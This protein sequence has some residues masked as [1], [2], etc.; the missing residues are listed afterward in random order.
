MKYSIGGLIND[1][2]KWAWMEQHWGDRIFNFLFGYCEMNFNNWTRA[3]THWPKIQRILKAKTGLEFELFND[4]IYVY[5]DEQYM[6]EHLLEMNIS[7]Y[8][9]PEPPPSR[10]RNMLNNLKNNDEE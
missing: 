9:R 6:D 8:Q 5:I 1:Q 3:K 4:R 7:L 10:I 2:R